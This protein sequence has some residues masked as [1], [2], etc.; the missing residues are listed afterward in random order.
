[1]AKARSN[2]ANQLGN[3]KICQDTTVKCRVPAGLSKGSCIPQVLKTRISELMDLKHSFMVKNTKPAN[4]TK[5]GRSGQPTYTPVRPGAR[6]SRAWLPVSGTEGQRTLGAPFLFRHRCAALLRTHRSPMTVP[7]LLHT[8]R[9]DQ[10]LSLQHRGI[11]LIF[12][13]GT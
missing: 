13:L 2:T 8:C 9:G 7:P 12:S 3:L 5:N 4:P 6:S 1:M 11:L 10:D